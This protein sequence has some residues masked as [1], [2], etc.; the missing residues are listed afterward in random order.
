MRLFRQEKANLDERTGLI[1]IDQTIERAK[2]NFEVML[3][4]I[5]EAY[6]DVNLS[7]SSTWPD[8]ADMLQGCMAST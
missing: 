7:D 1:Q 6:G 3:E 4:R 2:S 5:K 8:I